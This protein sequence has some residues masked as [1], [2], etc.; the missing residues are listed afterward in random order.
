MTPGLYLVWPVCIQ[1]YSEKN[2]LMFRKI[3]RL[4]I[5]IRFR[6]LSVLVR[7][8]IY[9]DC[10]CLFWT[11]DLLWQFSFHKCE[12]MLPCDQM[13]LWF[14]A[15]ALIVLNHG[16]AAPC[17]VSWWFLPPSAITCS[18]MWAVWYC[19]LMFVHLFETSEPSR[20]P[21]VVEDKIGLESLCHFQQNIG[22]TKNFTSPFTIERLNFLFIFQSYSLMINS[23]AISF[24][25]RTQKTLI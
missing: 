1:L 4:V 25:L 19:L 12:K 10:H 6:C 5:L 17:S 3:C 18:F 8:K 2:Q 24:W 7:T 9:R 14:H 23:Q 15:G 20:R 13:W 21:L 16:A 11:S 22:Q